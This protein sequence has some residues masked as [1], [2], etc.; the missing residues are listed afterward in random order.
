MNIFVTDQDPVKSAIALDDARVNKMITESIQMLA[1][2]LD[3]HQCPNLPLTKSGEPY[4]VKGPHKNHPCTI[5]TGNT[6]ANYVWLWEHTNTLCLE[7][8]HRRLKYQAGYHNLDI[9]KAMRIYIPAG[10]LEPFQNSS[11]YK[12]LPDT[13]EAYK[14]TMI[15]KWD[16]D[17]RPPVWTNQIKPDWY[18]KV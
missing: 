6:C 3:R 15:Y 7:W 16:H 1:Y 11:M 8:F 9:L 4:K 5:W 12:D 18:Q 13:I 17:K 10:P 2:A 14:A